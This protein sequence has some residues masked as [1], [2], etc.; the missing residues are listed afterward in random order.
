MSTNK[1]FKKLTYLYYNK[2]LFSEDICVEFDRKNTALTKL[3]SQ[4]L[5]A[6]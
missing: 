4:L 6:T 2:Y 3:E 5:R 1:Y